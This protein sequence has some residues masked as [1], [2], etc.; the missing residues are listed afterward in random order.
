MI[1]DDKY[2][3]IIYEHPKCNMLEC[4]NIINEYYWSCNEHARVQSGKEKYGMTRD[5]AAAICMYT[6]FS[7]K[8]SNQLNK[9]C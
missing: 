8:I 6:Y 1:I 3:F 7:K 5:E 4:S 9:W 2:E